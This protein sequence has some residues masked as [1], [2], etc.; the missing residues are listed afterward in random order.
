[1]PQKEALDFTL[2]AVGGVPT[3]PSK[4]WQFRGNFASDGGTSSPLRPRRSQNI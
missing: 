1:M 2:K 3:K 4:S